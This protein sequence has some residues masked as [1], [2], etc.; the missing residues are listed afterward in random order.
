ML[1][2]PS[3]AGYPDNP[4]F[5]NSLPWDPAP[6]EMGREIARTPRR[7]CQ[8][9]DGKAEAQGN[10]GGR[11]PAGAASRGRRAPESQELSE[12]MAG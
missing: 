3:N 11:R 7:G 2:V 9:R 8:C 12:G 4:F 6:P 1:C 5:P 10:A